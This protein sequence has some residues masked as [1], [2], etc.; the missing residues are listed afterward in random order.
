MNHEQ[1]TDTR[2]AAVSSLRGR[3]RAVSR[4][5]C[6]AGMIGAELGAA[7]GIFAGQTGDEG[8]TV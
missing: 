2:R 6:V 5:R 4:V 7:L 1:S 8:Q 3:E